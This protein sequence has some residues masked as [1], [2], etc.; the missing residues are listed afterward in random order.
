MLSCWTNAKRRRSLTKYTCECACFEVHG[1]LRYT[2]E[3]D[4]FCCFFRRRL[5]DE[6]RREVRLLQEM[7]LEDGELHSEGG[8][9]ERKFHWRNISK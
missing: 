2:Y 8:R 5:L 7:L 9:R 3:T 6:D 1:S 4:T